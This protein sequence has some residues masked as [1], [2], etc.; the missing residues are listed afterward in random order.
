MGTIMTKSEFTKLGEKFYDSLVK[1]FKDNDMISVGREGIITGSPMYGCIV[2]V[3]SNDLTDEEYNDIENVIDSVCNDWDEKTDYGWD[4]DGNSFWVSI[5]IDEVTPD[6]V[7]DECPVC[8]AD[9]VEIGDDIMSCPYCNP[10]E[11]EDGEGEDG[12]G[13]DGEGEDREGEDG[14]GED[15]EGEDGEKVCPECGEVIE[16]PD[17]GCPY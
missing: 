5:S 15:G 11:G 12:E 17:E 4:G 16:D 13:E 14:E 9:L 8:G 2:Q 1:A 6:P 10:M 7:E 3:D